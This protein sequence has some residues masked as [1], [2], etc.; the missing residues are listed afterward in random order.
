MSDATRLITAEELERF[1]DDDHRYELVEG[2]IV[3]MSPTGCEHGRI[4]VTLVSL[5]MQHVRA[6]RYGQVV[7]EV[8]FKLRTNPDT[9]RGP[10]VAFVRRERLPS[11]TLR[12]F[13]KG[14]PDLAVEVLSPDDRPS[15]MRVKVEEYLTSGALGVVVV[16]P[17][18]ET[19]T[20]H[21][22]LSPSVTARADEELDLD[23]IIQGFRC[24]VRAIF[25]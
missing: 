7:S 12:G 2:R 9:V 19:V 4:V 10:D 15:E 1:P 5:L 14:P 17:A 3:R 22:R 18:E 24:P 11:K 25:E 16:D 21:R 6:G 23:D 8:G 20:I 13:W